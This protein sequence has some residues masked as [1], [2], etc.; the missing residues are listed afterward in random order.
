M[1]QIPDLSNECIFKAVR[2]SGKGGQHVNKVS[3]KIELYFSITDSLILDEKQKNILLEKL[4][5]LLNEENVLRI[6]SDTHRSQKQNKEEALNKLQILITKALTPQ[7]KRIKTKT[8]KGVVA[9][10]REEKKRK[11]EVKHLRK[12][13]GL[14]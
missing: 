13:P 6:T 5:H 9:K 8:P 12:K 11:S 1:I 7:K 4:S 2:S 14:D 3:T 10:R